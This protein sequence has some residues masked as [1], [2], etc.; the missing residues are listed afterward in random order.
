[1]T[2]KQKLL[3]LLKHDFAD[4]VAFED[5]VV[6][7]M[8]R[9]SDDFSA[10]RI[11]NFIQML[12]RDPMLDK[13]AKLEKVNRI[14]NERATYLKCYLEGKMYESEEVAR[15]CV[16]LQIENAKAIL[17]STERVAL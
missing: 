15:E 10:T 6:V 1:M 17:E 14:A 4:Y 2:D 9:Y 5:I 11:C 12:N 16:D 8:S 3:E 13:I 7:Y